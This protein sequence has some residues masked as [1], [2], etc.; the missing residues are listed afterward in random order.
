MKK[1]LLRILI[2]VVSIS[3]VLTFSI[4]GCKAEEVVPIEEEAPAEEEV[5]E[6][7]EVEEYKDTI[8]LAENHIVRSLDPHKLICG[9]ARALAY[10]M[11]E[12][13]VEYNRDNPSEYLPGLAES[14]D[15]N[16]DGTEWIFHLRKGVKFTTGN[17]LT[18]EDVKYS[19]ER[20]MRIEIV[21]YPPIAQFLLDPDNPIEIIDDYTVKISLSKGFAGLL[22]LLAV[23]YMGILDKTEIQKY[24]TDDDPE[25]SIWLNDNSIGTGPF[26]LKE[27]VRNERIVLEKNED[28]WGIKENYHRV[29]QYKTFISL[30]I[31]EPATQAMMLEKGDVDFCKELLTDTLEEL[32]T[33]PDIKVEES[34]IFTLTMFTMNT[35]FEPFSDPKVRLA[36]KYAIDYDT[37]LDEIISAVRMDR[38][39]S[40]PLIGSDEDVLVN[41]DLD[42]A[43]QLMSESNYPDGFEV[44]YFIGTGIG[45]GAEWEVLG[46]KIQQDLEKIGIN[47]NI[48][49]YDWSVM[50]EKLLSGDFEAMQGWT[51]P[52]FSDTEG[53][54]SAWG[55]PKSGDLRAIPWENDKIIELADKGL[56][57]IDLEERYKIYRE[58]S[59]IF[60]EDG[61]VAFIGQQLVGVAF[62]SDVYGW[63]GNPPDRGQCDYARLYRE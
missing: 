36:I 8:I 51:G 15:V 12:G 16:D 24:I 48:E 1:L 44:S 3:V 55:R 41:Y 52:V 46:I 45:L 31:P 42:K 27:W 7:E 6:E 26:Y 18:A 20:G 62:R 9:Q 60:V 32:K 14:W 37:I 63:E 21:N 10:Q 13:L 25:G 5:A 59:E 30:N 54:L 23:T 28:Y 29:P 35:A 61:P 2:L 33:N 43:K 40:K 57:E 4:S 22:S 38:P 17:E 19:F 34:L 11:Y 56:N 53:C 49:Q 58:L 50:D 47:A 39:I